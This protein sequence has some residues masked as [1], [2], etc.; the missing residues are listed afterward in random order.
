MEQNNSSE[1][2]NKDSLFSDNTLQELIELNTKLKESLSNKNTQ[3]S[4]LNEL[5]QKIWHSLY[6][7]NSFKS[8]TDILDNII[9]NLQNFILSQKDD[10]INLVIETLENLMMIFLF[11]FDLKI[12]KLGF[13]LLKFLID[14]LEASYCSELL[15]YF[16]KII[17]LLNI[18]KRINN[19]NSS[20]VSSIIIYNISL[21]I[22]IILANEQ[23][24]KENK[25]YFYDFIKKNILDINL[26]YLLFLPL[27]NNE[28]KNNKIFGN[29]EIKLIYEKIGE[30]LNTTYTDFTNNLQRK[31]NDI[32]FIKE[33]INKIGMLCK[34][35][36]C[37]TFDCHRTYIIDKLIK[38][39]V[40][41]SQRIF[42]TLSYLLELKNPDIKFPAETIENIVSYF[43]TLGAFP[44]ENIL[45]PMSFINKMYN[46]YSSDYLSIIIYLIEEL[47][48]LSLNSDNNDVSRNKKIMLVVTQLIEIVFRKNMERNNDK[49]CLDIYD[50]Y[51]VNKIYEIL[52]KFDPNLVIS[53]NKFPNTFKFYF[54]DK[55]KNYFDE[56]EKGFNHKNYEYN[57][58]KYLNCIHDGNMANHSINKQSFINCYNKFIDFKNSIKEPLDIKDGF[59]ID[60]NLENA[61]K[62]IEN[63]PN[64]SYDDFRTFFL[65]NSMEMFN[66]ICKNE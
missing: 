66:Q 30:I 20:Y 37:V 5:R 49:I 1:A 43:K 35:L 22:Y 33:K 46:D 48:K 55:D 12:I 60:K 52:L 29:D 14:N 57:S 10:I 32:S 25:K 42:D 45:K 26:L 36:N 9:K 41:L 61:R 13:S 16:I 50:L 64:I 21:S 65:K 15:E 59:D 44:F 58:Q 56:M 38:N 40:P 39:M 6:E 18:K 8:N 23:I 63:K 17:Q 27:A 47:S 53:E 19:E 54:E 51:I 3:T 24:L 34:I 7:S 31:K 2:N 62:E 4:F 28:M 11:H